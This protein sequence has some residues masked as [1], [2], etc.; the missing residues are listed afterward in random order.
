MLKASRKDTKKG[1]EMAIMLGVNIAQLPNGTQFPRGHDGEQFPT[2]QKAV[3]TETSLKHD[4]IF[5]VGINA[6]YI[7]AWLP[8]IDPPA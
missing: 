1:Q 2:W 5:R 7:C 4:H 6:R 3:P 8:T